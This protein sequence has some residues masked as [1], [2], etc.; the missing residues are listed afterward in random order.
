MKISSG[1]R[2]PFCRRGKCDNRVLTFTLIYPHAW[3]EYT[4]CLSTTGLHIQSFL[5]H[6]HQ[7]PGCLATVADV[8]IWTQRVLAG[9]TFWTV[10]GYFFWIWHTI[11][12]HGTSRHLRFEP[13]IT[14]TSQWARWH[15][16]SPASR[17][18]TQPFIQAQIK[19]KYQ[20][21]AS[22]AFV[23]GVHRWPVNSPHKWPVTRK[24]F[25]FD[26]VIMSL[27]NVLCNEEM[28]TQF[29]DAYMH[30]RAEV[31]FELWRKSI[32]LW[33]IR[34]PQNI[35]LSVVLG[36]VQAKIMWFTRLILYFCD[37]EEAFFTFTSLRESKHQSS[38]L[39]AL[40]LCVGNPPVT[41]GF[42]HKDQ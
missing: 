24:M 4:R 10:W 36:Y 19:K 18:F 38:L 40:I 11:S 35:L 14:V 27:S 3:H 32:Q 1:K 8:F 41:G 33:F 12:T 7:R 25:P 23:W 39:H 29:N 28:K 20:S 37:G 13:Y 16:K 5:T 42:P 2:W 34:H 22:Q 15:L 17:L 26:D 6:R 30:G 9:I 31:D 21:S